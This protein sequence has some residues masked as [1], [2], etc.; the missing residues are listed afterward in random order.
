MRWHASALVMAAVVLEA[1]ICQAQT[2]IVQ[3][4]FTASDGTALVGR[5][6]DVD[7][8]GSMYVAHGGAWER[9][10]VGGNA[11]LGADAGLDLSIA[12][13]GSYTKPTTMTI[14]ATINLGTVGGSDFSFRG[15]GLGFNS[16]LVDPNAYPTGDALSFQHFTG[17]VVNPS[18]SVRLYG[19]GD[20]EGTLVANTTVDTVIGSFATPGGNHSVRYTVDTTTG[21]I[22]NIYLDSAAVTAPSTTLFTDAA[23]AYAG[24]NAQSN[25]G[26]SLGKVDNF[27]LYDGIPPLFPVGDFDHNGSVDL[28]DYGILKSHWFQTVPG[29]TAGDIDGDGFVNISD[30]AAFKLAYQGG[31]G[32]GL[33]VPTPEPT[34]MILAIAALP[35]FLFARRRRL[36]RRPQ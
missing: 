15:I 13:A 31:G 35:M 12:S 19:Y 2:T 34:T 22:S 18:G 36:L 6:P 30:F 26:G 28:T 32:T 3:D 5:S 7:L 20:Y 29:G 23:T 14:S 21:G 17:L 16:T 9:D 10:I 8:P 27:T 1:A 25:S 33:A 24:F 11:T 4:S